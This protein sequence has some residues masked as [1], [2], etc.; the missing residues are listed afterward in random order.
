MATPRFAVSPLAR[1]SRSSA[2]RRELDEIGPERLPAG[3]AQ[4]DGA[5]LER[6]ASRIALDEPL[7]LERPDEARGRALRQARELRELADGRRLVLLDDVHEQLRCAL[8]R[9]G[10]GLRDHEAVQFS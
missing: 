6:A 10:S 1:A 8:D 9:L 5:G 2:G 4:K 7:A 3:V